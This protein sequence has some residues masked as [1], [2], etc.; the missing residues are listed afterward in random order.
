MTGLY[1]TVYLSKSGEAYKKALRHFQDQ[2][3]DVVELKVLHVNSD[4]EVYS[5]EW[6]D[7]K[8]CVHFCAGFLL[9][10]CKLVKFR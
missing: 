6:L 9:N 10:L 5:G 1:Q 2:Y 7:S 8:G 4:N 3:G